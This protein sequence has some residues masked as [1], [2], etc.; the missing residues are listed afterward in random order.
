LIASNAVSYG[1]LGSFLIVQSWLIGVGWV[2]YGGQLFGRWFHDARLQ[3]WA[4]SRRGRGEPGD[5][6]E[7]D[8]GPGSQS[9]PPA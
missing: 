7:G 1:A 8:K 6:E 2:I 4:D 9:S 5:G 3:P